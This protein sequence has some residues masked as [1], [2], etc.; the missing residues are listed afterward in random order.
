MVLREAEIHLQL[1]HLKETMDT[2]EDLVVE[3]VAVA[4]PLAHLK[5]LVINQDQV[6]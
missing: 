5:K 2:Q 1:H 4:E 3:W 6:R